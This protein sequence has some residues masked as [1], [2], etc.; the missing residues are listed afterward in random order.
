M[1]SKKDMF[2]SYKNFV[3]T[4]H[5]S[6]LIWKTK[7]ILMNTNQL[8]CLLHNQ[9]MEEYRRQQ[10][11]CSSTFQGKQPITHP[12]NI[13]RRYKNQMSQMIVV[14]NG[15]NTYCVEIYCYINFVDD[16]P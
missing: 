15:G 3:Y 1:V 16:H 9:N 12:I 11:N 7:T 2:Q 6:I 5:N 8:I 4:Q 13:K 10:S 14:L